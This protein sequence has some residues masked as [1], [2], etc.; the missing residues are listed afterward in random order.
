MMASVTTTFAAEGGL[1]VP[2]RHSSRSLA[3]AVGGLEDWASGQ[4]P[5]EPADVLGPDGGDH[6]LSWTGR[7]LE[8]N[9]HPDTLRKN[10]AHACGRLRRGA[11]GAT[12]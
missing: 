10:A 8:G 6:A 3:S 2:G 1:L 4:L 5:A 12:A 11:P 9:R 7:A